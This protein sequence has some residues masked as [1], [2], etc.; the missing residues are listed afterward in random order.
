MNKVLPLKNKK[1][2]GWNL[3]FPN[4]WFECFKCGADYIG[5]YPHSLFYCRYCRWLKK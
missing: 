4:T 5:V 3:A 2:V 1:E